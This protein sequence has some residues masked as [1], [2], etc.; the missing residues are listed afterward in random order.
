[1]SIFCSAICKPNFC[2]GP[3]SN[4]CTDCDYPYIRSGT[5]CI[6]DSNSGYV[7]YGT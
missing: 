5:T 2:T 7:L 1:M 6:I 4:Q 3:N